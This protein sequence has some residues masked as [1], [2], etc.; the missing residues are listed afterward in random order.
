MCGERVGLDASTLLPV[1]RKGITV[2]N[3][4]LCIFQGLISMSLLLLSAKNVFN[5]EIMYSSSLD[6]CFAPQ[7]QLV[8]LFLP[9]FL[10]SIIS[11]DC[12]LGVVLPCLL[13]K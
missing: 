6:V 2:L 8:R 1:G 9:D 10:G 11:S 5:T 3:S 12:A 13:D 7:K 4:C